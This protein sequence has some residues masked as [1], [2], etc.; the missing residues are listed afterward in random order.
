MQIV[1]H[2]RRTGMHC[3]TSG[4]M[5]GLKYLPRGKEPFLINSISGLGVEIYPFLYG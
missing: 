4:M 5:T 2:V 1:V 3:P